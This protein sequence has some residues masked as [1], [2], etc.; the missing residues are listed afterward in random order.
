M[1]YERSLPQVS[2]LVRTASPPPPPFHRS[3]LVV[4]SFHFLQVSFSFRVAR[5]GPAAMTASLQ[6]GGAA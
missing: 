3:R 6:S 1:L 2:N 4:A 5:P